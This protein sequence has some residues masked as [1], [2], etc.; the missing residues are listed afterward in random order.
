MKL[1][2]MLTMAGSKF[3]I[4]IRDE[5]EQL[6]ILE[7]QLMLICSAGN[8]GE[9]KRVR[10][11]TKFFQFGASHSLFSETTRRCETREK[12]RTQNIKR[13][14]KCQ[15]KKRGDIVKKLKASIKKKDLKIQSLNKKLAK[16][17]EK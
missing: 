9:G 12:K 16:K 11:S 4:D 1:P 13:Q 17:T 14:R 8:S 3:C 7:S 5:L 10:K 15:D 6:K 2:P